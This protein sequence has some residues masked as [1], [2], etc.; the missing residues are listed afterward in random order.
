V[1]G[2]VQAADATSPVG[3]P[4]AAPPRRSPRVAAAAIAA[5]VLIAVVAAGAFAFLPKGGGP[6]GS[7]SASVP[8]AVASAASQGPASPS[9]S[10]ASVPPESPSPTPLPTATPPTPTP[11]PSGQQ[12]RILGITISGGRYVVDYKVFHYTQKLP[13]KHVHF[14]FDTV[15]AK[16]AGMPGKGPWFVYAGP[17]PFTG[18]K[19]TDRPAGAT[20]MCILFANPDHS[21]VQGTGNCVDLPSS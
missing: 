21:V 13:G 14:F 18:Y 9:P 5:V 20:Q 6:S 17:I 8:I 7:P 1:P 16:Q 15:P 10:V 3:D 12:A 19:L 11:T 4:S 2:A